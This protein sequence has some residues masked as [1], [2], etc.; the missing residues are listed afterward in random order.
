MADLASLFLDEKLPS[1]P[2]LAAALKYHQFC[3]EKGLPEGEY[4]T[5][6]EAAR[7]LG[8]PR[9]QFDNSGKTAVLLQGDTAHAAA[10]K[11]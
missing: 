6:A 10:L 1:L 11:G 7:M 5:K 9:K 8:A 3:Q 4:G 2:V